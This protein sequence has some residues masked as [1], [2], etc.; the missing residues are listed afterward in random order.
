[1]HHFQALLART[2]ASSVGSPCGVEG[3]GLADNC[4]ICLPRVLSASDVGGSRSIGGSRVRAAPI[5]ANLPD[6]R[7]LCYTI[8]PV[9]LDP[10]G[11]SER[12]RKTPRSFD[13]RVFGRS[14]AWLFFTIV[15]GVVYICA[16]SNACA[17][18]T[19]LYSFGASPNDGVIPLGGFVQAADGAL[20]GT[21]G[22][23][24]SNVFNT[25]FPTGTVFKWLASTG[26][27][28]VEVFPTAGPTTYHRG[29]PCCNLIK[30]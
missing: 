13:S 29:R 19:I 4:C 21:T 7:P 1:L 24:L 5:T 17:Q 26:L 23:Q 2:S 16:P 25:A 3:A 9:K 12:V 27:S 11:L 22:A 8:T 30:R 6:W 14:F 15:L 28:Y 10:I 18:V 20:Y